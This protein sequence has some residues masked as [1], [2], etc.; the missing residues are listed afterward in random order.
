MTNTITLTDEQ[1]NALNNGQKITIKP[2]KKK[3]ELWTPTIS[4]PSFFVHS[5]GL[6]TRQVKI[7]GDRSEFYNV[8]K[9]QEIAEEAAKYMRINNALISATKTVDPDFN[10][11]THRTNFYGLDFCVPDNRWYI[12]LRKDCYDPAGTSTREKAEQML[13]IV[14]GLDLFADFR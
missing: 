12:A 5:Y 7:H 2:P 4:S 3:P 6:T 8:F 14:N 10:Q 1:Y 11:F 13:E 9:T